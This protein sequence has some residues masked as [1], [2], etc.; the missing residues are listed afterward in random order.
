LK[1][2]SAVAHST[3]SAIANKNDNMPRIERLVI[4]SPNGGTRDQDAL[5]AAPDAIRKRYGVEQPA[6]MAIE[7]GNAPII[8]ANT[9]WPD[10]FIADRVIGAVPRAVAEGRIGREAIEQSYSRI[11]A[12]S[13]G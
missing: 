10:P 12:A 9:K 13:I 11:L 4:C 2:S 5:I 3:G 8:I 6:G 1:K 7:A